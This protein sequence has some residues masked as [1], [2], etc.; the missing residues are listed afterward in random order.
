M[1][2][3]ALRHQITI[4]APTTTKTSGVQSDTWTDYAIVCA[5]VRQMRAYEKVAA[6]AQWPGADSIITMRYTP[7]VTGN[8]RVIFNGMIYSILGQPNNVDG[9]NREM[10]LTCQSGVKAS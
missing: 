5:S 2:A 1:R 8:M 7:G 4:Q 6:S 10:I 3:G 9:R